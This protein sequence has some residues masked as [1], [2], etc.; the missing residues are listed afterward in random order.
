MLGTPCRWSLAW[1]SAS[2]YEE[3][4]HI[5]RLRRFC[6][7]WDS[8]RA[9]IASSRGPLLPREVDVETARHFLWWVEVDDNHTGFVQSAAM[10]EGEVAVFSD[11]LERLLDDPTAIARQRHIL[12]QWDAARFYID[13]S[14][15]P[16]LPRELD[17]LTARH[18]S[19]H[20][21]CVR[22]CTDAAPSVA[23]REAE[24]ADVDDFLW[25]LDAYGPQPLG[26]PM[27]ALVSPLE[28]RSPPMS[29]FLPSP[30][31]PPPRMG[32]RWQ[33]APRLGS[34]T[35]GP[36]QSSRS[37]PPAGQLG[38]RGVSAP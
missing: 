38:C 37:P 28:G 11:L 32:G 4:L 35:P 12:D 24:V 8:A 1:T 31:T 21:E 6:T 18:F 29:P 20:M 30:S 22:S 34:G 5:A 15:G 10:R 17:A 7:L 3:P 9:Y 36:L 23:E 19:W 16:L 25:R 33:S 13:D 2:P 14:R 26:A 27:A